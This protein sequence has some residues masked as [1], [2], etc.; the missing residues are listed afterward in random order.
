M[1][2]APLRIAQ[3]EAAQMTRAGDIAG[4]NRRLAE[5]VRQSA[6]IRSQAIAPQQP[7]PP[8]TT[9]PLAAPGTPPPVPSPLEILEKRFG[10]LTAFQKSMIPGPA[11]ESAIMEARIAAGANPMLDAS[12]PFGLG[13]RR[14]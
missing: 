9:G 12:L 3:I 6:A 5:G 2:A 8:P 7:A 13:A 4:A 11:R 10:H 1:A 14:R